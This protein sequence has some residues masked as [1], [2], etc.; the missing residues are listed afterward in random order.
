MQVRIYSILIEDL[1]A[2]SYLLFDRRL[3]CSMNLACCKQDRFDACSGGICNGEL[4]TCKK[5]NNKNHTFLIQIC[6]SIML[7]KKLNCVA[8]RIFK[9][10]LS[11]ILYCV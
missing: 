9:C 3:C 2:S 8:D 11:Y 4:G 1:T 6:L 10:Y 5:N 7:H